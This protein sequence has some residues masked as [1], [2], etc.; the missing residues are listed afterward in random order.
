MN[1]QGAALARKFANEDSVVLLSRKATSY[2]PI[3]DEI[4]ASGGEALGLSTDV[5][6]AESLESAFA[7]LR[8]RFAGRSLAAAIYNTGGTLM[9]KPFLELSQDGFAGPF[10]TTTLGGFLFSQAVLPLLLQS[11]GMKY[12]PTLTFTGMGSIGTEMA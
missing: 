1:W 8:D 4:T 10:Q 9:R 12:P 2:Q 7:Q 5:S 11:T 6:D 3:V